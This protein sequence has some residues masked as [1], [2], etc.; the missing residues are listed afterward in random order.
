MK[1]IVITS[2]TNILKKR[3][4]LYNNNDNYEHGVQ[5]FEIFTSGSNKY[6]LPLGCTQPIIHG[7]LGDLRHSKV[8]VSDGGA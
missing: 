5:Q 3:K 8:N 1:P 6:F 4:P 7:M 2:S